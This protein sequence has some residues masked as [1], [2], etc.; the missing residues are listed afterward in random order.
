MCSVQL[1]ERT[2]V[3]TPCRVPARHTH[4]WTH[5]RTGVRDRERESA[6]GGR[7]TPAHVKTNV[8]IF[9]VKREMASERKMKKERKKERKKACNIYIYNKNK[10]HKVLPAFH[11][12]Y[13]GPLFAMRACTKKP[14]SNRNIARSCTMNSVDILCRNSC[15]N[16]P[17]L[18]VG[19]WVGMLAFG[20]VK[21]AV[22]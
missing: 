18:G 6:R 19:W 8:E 5:A 7:S 11:F 21:R 15:R 10:I 12:V 16:L 14:S 17:R 1:L 3:C 4:T 20:C 13:R 22:V 2:S 9:A